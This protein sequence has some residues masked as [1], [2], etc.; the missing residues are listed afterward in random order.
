MIQHRGSHNNV[1]INNAYKLQNKQGETQPHFFL[2]IKNTCACFSKKQNNKNTYLKK[3]NAFF[4]NISRFLLIVL[5]I[6]FIELI[7][8]KLVKKRC[9]IYKN[10]IKKKQSVSKKANVFLKNATCFFYNNKR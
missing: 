2:N 4:V 6:D 9:F 10:T 8:Q 1:F 3:P 7:R 5:L